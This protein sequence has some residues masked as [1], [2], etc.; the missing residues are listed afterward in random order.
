MWECA[1]FCRM[2]QTAPI[3]LYRW[4]VFLAAAGYL[5]NSVLTSNWDPGGPFRYLTIWALVLSLFVAARVLMISYNRSN[6]RFDALV[7][8][9]AVVNAMVV[10]LYWRLYF[11]DP[12]SVTN[13]GELGAFWLEIYMHGL[14]PLLMWIDAIFINRVFRRIWSG[15]LVLIGIVLAYVACAE[16]FV[17][18][19]NDSPVGSVT[20]GLPY[21]FLNNLEFAGR[22]VFYGTN[23]VVALILLFAFGAVAWVVRRLF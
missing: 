12:T 17:Q 19:F 2:E 1:A 4:I 6:R 15:A 10:F 20:T 22:S 3:R 5:A 8:A 9:T 21:P 18:R 13:D 11:A 7:S 14:G 23:V 16:L